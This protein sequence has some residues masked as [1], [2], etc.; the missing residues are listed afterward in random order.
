MCI[1]YSSKV[2]VQTHYNIVECID[3]IQLEGYVSCAHWFGY[4]HVFSC[5]NGDHVHT[6]FRD[7]YNSLRSNGYFVEV[8]GS[9]FTCFDA[10]QYGLNPL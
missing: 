2:Y 10:T 7:M 4:K 8:L 1:T 9:P 5:R 3:N 6:N